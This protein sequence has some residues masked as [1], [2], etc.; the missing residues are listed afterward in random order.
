MMHL[1][2]LFKYLTFFPILI[3]STSLSISAQ[4]KKDIKNNKVKTVTEIITKDGKTIKDAFHRCDKN[5]N[6]LEETNYDNL[7]K[8][9]ERT[10]YK[11]NNINEKSEKVSFDAAG[12]QTAKETYKY[13]ADEEKSEE[14]IYNGNNILVSRSVY[15]F[16]NK[17]LRKEKKT[18]DAKGTLIQTK[19]Y[20]YEY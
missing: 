12:K 8:I 11:Y 15:S 5:G 7:G 4:S 3:F 1:K 6:V 19:T 20:Q 17:G 14:N 16:N 13:N 10:T 2:S 18:F 9:K